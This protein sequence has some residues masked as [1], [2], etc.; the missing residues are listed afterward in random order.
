MKS[1]FSGEVVSGTFSIENPRLVK[2]IVA[3][4][5]TV[6]AKQGSMVAYRG[7][8]KFEHAK[9]GVKRLFKRA[10][11]GESLVLMKVYGP[12]E[13]YLADQA[14]HVHI[15]QLEDEAVTGGGPSVLAFESGIDW[16]INRLRG[17]AAGI[18]AGGLFNV[19]LRGR[20]QVAIT[21]DG[22]PLL[23]EI[24]PDK[25]VFCD[26]AAAVL[27]S[28]GLQANLHTD[29]QAKTLIGLGSGESVQLGL[30]GTG[31]VLVQPSEGQPVQS[32][33][34]GGGGL[35]SSIFS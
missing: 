34:G 10:A 22:N 18:L 12:G 6:M 27:W 30:S 32:S 15:I 17:G 1:T 19:T 24:T 8:A 28:G 2:T 9:A 3:D 13:V 33:G 4:G 26:P 31:W 21:S 20:G 7:H 5:A 29:V 23:L 25:P 14:K 35:F 11:T 16:D